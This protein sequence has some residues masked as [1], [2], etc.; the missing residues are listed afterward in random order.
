MSN[1]DHKLIPVKSQ[2]LVRKARN[3]C[4]SVTLISIETENEYEQACNLVKEV[5]SYTK[6]IEKHRKDTVSP[7]NNQVSQVN[8]YFKDARQPLTNIEDKLRRAIAQYHQELERKKREAQRKAD[9]E[10]E[11]ERQ[12]LL[13]QSKKESKK[14]QQYAEQGKEDLAQQHHEKSQTKQ[15]LAE[16]ITTP[17]VEQEAPKI[18]GISYRDKW[19]AQITDKKAFVQHCLQNNS[20]DMIMVD[21]KKLNELAR[22]LKGSYNVPGVK[23]L[24]EKIPVVRK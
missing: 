7:F 4:A 1:N 17:E 24:S 3:F 2:E 8:G 15:Q 10:A 21:E 11:K 9:E 6:L 5:A 19:S 23:F 22:T 12:R 16:S 18:E 13:E 20:L 14:S